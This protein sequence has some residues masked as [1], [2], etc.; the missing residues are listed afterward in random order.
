MT[1]SKSANEA[2]RRERANSGVKMSGRRAIAVSRWRAC[3]AL[4][5]PDVLKRCIPGGQSLATENST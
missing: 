2:V 1:S 4:N 5:D 3:E